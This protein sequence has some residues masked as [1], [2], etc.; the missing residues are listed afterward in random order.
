MDNLKPPGEMDFRPQVPV[1][2][3]GTIPTT[4]PEQKIREVS[5]A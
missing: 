5:Y 4:L 2:Y 1:M 3:D